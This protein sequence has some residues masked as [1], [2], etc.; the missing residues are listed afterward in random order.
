MWHKSKLIDALIEKAEHAQ[1]LAEQGQ[2]YQELQ[3]ELLAELPYVPLWY[4][5]NVLATHYQVTGYTLAADGNYD[6]LNTIKF[7]PAIPAAD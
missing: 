2:L 4:E 7:T 3:V 1:S 5:D 6:G